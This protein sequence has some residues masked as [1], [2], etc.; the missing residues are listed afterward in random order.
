M[1]ANKIGKEEITDVL[2]DMNAYG[3]KF[4]S[5]IEESTEDLWIKI[6]DKLVSWD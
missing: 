4:T 3:Q 1:L 5:Q 6:E 2:P